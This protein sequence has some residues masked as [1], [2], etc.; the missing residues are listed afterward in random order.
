MDNNKGNLFDKI[1][2][3]L[4][5][6]LPLED[7]AQLERAAQADPALAQAISLRHLEFEVAEAAVADDIRAQFAALRNQS[8]TTP[9]EKGTPSAQVPEPR[10]IP[11]LKVLCLAL[12]LLGLGLLWH[13]FSR[14]TAS[15]APAPESPA[16]PEKSQSA[17]MPLPEKPKVPVASNTQKKPNRPKPITPATEGRVLA[18]DLYK[19]PDFESL[20]TASPQSS[21][22]S[23]TELALDALKANDYPSAIRML[24]PV[25]ATDPQY[26][27][28]RFLLGHSL[29][30]GQRYEQATRV[31][32]T[33]AQSKVQPWAE[34]AEWYALLSAL[35]N[36]QTETPAFRVNLK[37]MADDIGH[38]FQGE[39]DA[40]RKK[41]GAE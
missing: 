5:G 32:E 35:A 8:P 3:Y 23:T 4:A 11:L 37:K 15:V 26:W 19:R 10:R 20:R 9:S 2:A 40:L 38:P 33:V 25:G 13:H 7:A 41:I 18:G 17:P 6:H 24:E 16:A 31:F 39:A 14:P 12:A 22:I 30:S 34:E 28:A 21:T 27:K 36:G 29:V 1:D